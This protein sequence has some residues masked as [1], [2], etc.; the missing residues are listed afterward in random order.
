MTEGFHLST[1]PEVMLALPVAEALAETKNR[2]CHDYGYVFY[3]RA[4][5]CQEQDLSAPANAWRLLGQVCQMMLQPAATSAPFKPVWHS[6][7]ARSLVP[8]DIDEKTTRALYELARVTDDPELAARLCD[9]V[10]V[11]LRDNRA[12]RRAIQQYLLAA[13][14]MFDPSDWPRYVTRVERAARLARQINDKQQLARIVEELESRILSLDGTDPLYMTSRLMQL[15]HAFSSGNAETMSRIA[16]KAAQSAEKA[17]DFRR[18]RAHY[19]NLEKWRRQARDAEGERSARVAAAASYEHEAAFH[20]QAG[21][22]FAAIECLE[23]AHT[24]YRNIPDMGVKRDEVY[25]SLRELQIQVPGFLMTTSSEPIDISDAAAAS[26]EHVAGR[27]F[28]EALLALA[29]VTRPTDFVEVTGRVQEMG[30]EFPLSYM[31]G[32]VKI[33]SNGQIVAKRTSTL[34]VGSEEADKAL[35]ERVVEN[36]GLEYHIAAQAYILPAIDQI[37]LEHSPSVSDITFVCADNPIVPDGHED[38]FCQGI[39]AG[40]NKDFVAALSIL[41]PQI[42]NSLRWLLS[43]SGVDVTSRDKHGL[44]GFLQLGAVLDHENL[45]LRMESRLIKEMNVLFVDQHGPDL[46]NR[47]AHGLMKHADFASS[48]AIYAWWF[49]LFL[50]L[51]PVLQRLGKSSG[52]NDHKSEAAK[53]PEQD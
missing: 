41:V 50:C 38:L 15:L 22:I 29:T 17:P 11:R 26:R 40:L 45:Q 3:S 28:S 36:V 30:R 34:A 42:E 23:H 49:I 18:A 19:A 51:N 33:D 6:N 5:Q 24:A 27:P 46:R 20:Q 39:A 7:D 32:G 12:A 31:V 14:N 35:W 8:E 48:A 43:A 4:K 9:V 2:A 47:I 10:W 52:S 44:Q 21:N 37:I 1:P 16:F 13:E 53:P 25:T